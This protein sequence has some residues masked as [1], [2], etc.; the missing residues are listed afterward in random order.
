MYNTIV[1]HMDLRI[2]ANNGTIWHLGYKGFKIKFLQGIVGSL[3]YA[4]NSI[5]QQC[6]IQWFNDLN[7]LTDR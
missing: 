7:V 4:S 2:V 5:I 1:T 3:W 6:G